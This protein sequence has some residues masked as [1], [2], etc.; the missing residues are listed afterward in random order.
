MAD[1]V[2][3]TEVK[4]AHLDRNPGLTRPFSKRQAGGRTAV[5]EATSC[6][7]ERRTCLVAVR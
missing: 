7:E 6:W 2:Q 5:A 1:T 4:V 3:S